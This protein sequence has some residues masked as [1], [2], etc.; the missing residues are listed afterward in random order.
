MKVLLSSIMHIIITRVCI[1]I[2]HAYYRGPNSTIRG[3]NPTPWYYAYLRWCPGIRKNRPRPTGRSHS[4]NNAG[5]HA[6]LGMAFHKNRGVC[7]GLCTV[8]CCYHL[9]HGEERIVGVHAPRRAQGVCGE[10]RRR[11]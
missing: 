2:M 11:S 10:T 4:N 5:S 7:I 1:C 6:V 8:E 9:L 3:G